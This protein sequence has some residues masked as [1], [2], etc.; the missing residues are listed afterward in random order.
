MMLLFRPVFSGLGSSVVAFCFP[1]YAGGDWRGSSH[2]SDK[3]LMQLFPWQYW[4]L[5]Q[6]VL[7]VFKNGCFSPPIACN[8]KGYFWDLHPEN[9]M[10]FLD[11][12]A[13]ELWGFP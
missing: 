1:L 3:A 11:T 7:G 13:T 2:K 8:V 5:V 10:G 12:K 9:L 6:D 4:P